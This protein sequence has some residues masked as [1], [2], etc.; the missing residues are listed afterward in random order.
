M[1]E[2]DLRLTLEHLRGQLRR[3]DTV[4]K[5]SMAEQRRVNDCATAMLERQASRAEALDD[6]LDRLEHRLA[7]YT[8][9]LMTI[10]VL[11]QVVPKFLR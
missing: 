6:R 2:E 7:T 9:G 4:L 8:G 1:G 3:M 10:W 5:M 11:F